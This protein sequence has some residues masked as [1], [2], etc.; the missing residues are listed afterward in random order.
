M[1]P[2]QP[3]MYKIAPNETTYEEIHPEYC[4]TLQIISMPHL[5][6]GQQM[7]NKSSIVWLS[8]VDALNV[9]EVRVDDVTSAMHESD[10]EDI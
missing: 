4:T 1:N 7:I 8:I 10:R 6:D 3:S 9:V 5:V 2:M